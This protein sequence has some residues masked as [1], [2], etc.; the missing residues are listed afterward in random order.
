ML[1]YTAAEL[2]GICPSQP[3]PRPTR[4][5][6]FKVGLWLPR[7]R[8]PPVDQLIAVYKQR[9][10]LYP[11]VQQRPASCDL[12]AG[13]VGYYRHDAISAGYVEGMQIP[14]LVGHRPPKHDP[15]PPRTSVITAVPLQAPA[16]HHATAT[17]PQHP[18][19]LRPT[20][21]VLNTAALSKPGP[22]DHLATDMKSTGASVAVITKTH[23]KQKHAD[24]VIAIDVF[25]RDRVGRRGGGVALYV[26]TDL[27]ASIWLPSSADSRAFELL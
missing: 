14:T 27:Q 23:F 17:P 10:V 15:Q 24:S 1:M 21:Y 5:A 26:H 11:D 9:H 16:H 12:T 22:V 19:P 3:P 18:V 20:L 6:L 4:K 7:D 13:M 8:R 25:R 2:I